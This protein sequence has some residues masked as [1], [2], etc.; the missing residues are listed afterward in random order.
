MDPKMKSTATYFSCLPAILLAILPGKSYCQTEIQADSRPNIIFIL[1][2]D[3]DIQAISSYGSTLINTPGI[4]RLAQEGVRFTN[5]F[6]VISLCAPSRAALI[7][8]KYNRLNGVLR[9][10]DRLDEKQETFPKLL[11]Q[12]GYQ[13]ALIGKWHLETEP[14]GFDYYSVLPGQGKYFN[15]PMKVKG[16]PW[17]NGN[18]GGI[19]AEGYITDVITNQAIDWLK[20]TNA[21][22]P[23]LLMIHHKA[24]HGP[25]EYPEKYGK[26][27]ADADLPFPE[28]FNDDYSEKNPG[29]KDQNAGYSRLDHIYPN[30][31][32]EK[33]P[34]GMDRETYKKWAYQSFFKGYLR[35]VASLDENIGRLLRYLDE[36]GLA[37]N[38]LVV[39]TSDNGFFL[40]EHGLFNKM[41]MYEESMRLPLIIRFPGI[42]KPG[43]I[44]KEMVSILDFAP[45]FADFSNARIPSTLQGKSI[46]LLIESKKP[47]NWRES[48]YYHYFNQF[49]VPEHEGIRTKEY[50]LIRFYNPKG[51][52][53]NEMY[54]LNNDPGEMK[55]LYLNPKYKSVKKRLENSLNEMKTTFETEPEAK[56]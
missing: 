25:H 29:L 56:Y 9:I 3:H 23:F 22:K 17:S 10:G 24:P 31:F 8:G 4:D 44:N 1:A 48:I 46:R 2:D 47:V 53:F 5:C 13:T 50:K 52:S 51:N 28:T 34:E 14:Q 37:K 27:F 11:Q 45:T 43:S 21:G 15:C 32:T 38:T 30:H 39:Y 35:L 12:S 36:S 19:P 26:L 6:N 33:V 49:E 18:L 20:K 41:W 42:A 40:G 55:N 54:S 16:Q 7:T